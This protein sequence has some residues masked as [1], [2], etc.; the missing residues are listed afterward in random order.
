MADIV[1]R[2]AELGEAVDILAA[3]KQVAAD[4][5]L[6]FETLEQEEAAYGRIRTCAR[7]GESWIAEAAGHGI[8]GF[9]LVE[10]NELRRHYAENE[11]LEVRFAGVLGGGSNDAT[12]AQMI[13][14]V[15]DRMVPVA[16]TVSNANRSGLA[17][18][19]EAMGFRRLAS[20]GGEQR[21]RWEPGIGA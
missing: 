13:Q 17:Q 1:Y 8:V 18:S 2:Q 9:I 16:M 10:P 4:I 12:L 15:L 11:A 19:L 7:S 20:P 14:K 5:P 3:L 21:F 6:A